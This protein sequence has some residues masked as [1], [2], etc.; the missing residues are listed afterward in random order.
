MKKKIKPIKD[1]C[2][3]GKKVTDHHFKCNSCYSLMNKKE[4]RKR[5]SKLMRDYYKNK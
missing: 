1:K 4:D 5:K 3:C 2:K